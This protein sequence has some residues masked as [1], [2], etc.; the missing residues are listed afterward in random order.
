M[1]YRPLLGVPLLRDGKWIGVFTCLAPSRGRSRPSRLNWLAT[2]ADQAVIA[3]E[4]VRL[5]NECR[6]DAGLLGSS[7]PQQPIFSRSSPLPDR[8]RSR[9]LKAIAERS[10]RIV[11]AL[12]A[13]HA[14]SLTTSC[15]RTHGIAAGHFQKPM[16]HSGLVSLN[17]QP[18]HLGERRSAQARSSIFADVLKSISRAQGCAGSGTGYIGYRS[19]CAFRC[20]ASRAVSA[21]SA[22]P[23]RVDPF[24]EKQIE[25]LQTFADQAVIAI[26][27]VRLFEEVQ[28]RTSELS[29]LARRSPRRAGPPG[30]DRKTRLARPAHRR[31]SRMRSRTRSIS[32][33]TSLRYRR[34]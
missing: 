23:P 6:Q 34:N 25:L 29:Q 19:S 7:R 11:E 2:F 18:R 1:G 13:G 10:N 22:S 20:C 17:C 12:C 16:R 27:N 8:R 26:E 14:S 9:C 21:R 31:A 30:P 5:F 28:Q 15:M 32:S 4:N 3:I 24:T 33:I